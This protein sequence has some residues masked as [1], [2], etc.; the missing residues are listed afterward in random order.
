MGTG[1]EDRRRNAARVR[2][3]WM[4][5]ALVAWMLVV[6]VLS[7][8]AAL[9]H[10][11]GGLEGHLHLVAGGVHQPDHERHE[12][13]HR[14]QH[15]GLDDTHHHGETPGRDGKAQGSHEDVERVVFAFPKAPPVV[16]GPSE[17]VTLPSWEAL[18]TLALA[19]PANEGLEAVVAAR[20]AS[21][22]LR[23]DSHSGGT[24]PLRI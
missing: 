20:T 18:V 13:W 21:H 6:Q 17:G 10:A 23:G 4:A 12:S 9:I 16:D 22:E 8:T 15:A 11:H 24:L 1:A 5:A 19:V 3:R 14:S 7:G 2:G